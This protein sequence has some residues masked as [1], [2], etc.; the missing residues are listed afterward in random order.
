MLI[1]CSSRK[2]RSERQAFTRQV[3][4]TITTKLLVFITTYLLLY[5]FSEFNLLYFQIFAIYLCSQILKFRKAHF[6]IQLRVFFLRKSS[7]LLFSLK[8]EALR[9]EMYLIYIQI[10]KIRYY[11]RYR[12]QSL[13]LKSLSSWEWLYQRLLSRT[14]K[15]P[16]FLR[17]HKHL[18]NQYQVIFSTLA[19]FY[20]CFENQRRKFLLILV[21]SGK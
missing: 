10:R 2:S 12:L 6:G 21:K 13:S 8:N 7:T 18:Y 3:N 14:L 19:R 4:N 9:K 5:L 15:Q 16:L 1:Y 20:L 11:R 17:L